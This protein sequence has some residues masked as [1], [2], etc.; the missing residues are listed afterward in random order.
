MIY[1]CYTLFFL[2]TVNSKQHLSGRHMSKHA[3]ERPMRSN[4]NLK[5][6]TIPVA[7]QFYVCKA[8]KKKQE[9]VPLALKSD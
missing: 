5:N 8:R 9:I 3:S 1:C 2:H 6:I 7:P 4:T